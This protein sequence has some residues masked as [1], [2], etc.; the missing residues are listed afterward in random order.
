MLRRRLQMA[1]NGGGSLLPPE[2][3]ACEYLETDGNAYIILNVKCNDITDLTCICLQNNTSTEVN[4]TYIFGNGSTGGYSKQFS[5]GSESGNYRFYA[6]SNQNNRTSSTQSIDNELT[7]IFNK[8]TKKAI[9]NNEEK[10]ITYEIVYVGANDKLYIFAAK[11]NG[12][13]LVNQNNLKIKELYQDGLF[14]VVNCYIK[15]G[16]TFIDNK[17]VECTAGTAGMFDIQNNIFYTNDGPGQFSH[18]ADVNL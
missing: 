2:L 4:N 8:S 6:F 16:K 11:I 17:G 13:V 3:Q 18:G 5:L 10:T 12:S 9:F 1:G 14:H 7:F 15:A